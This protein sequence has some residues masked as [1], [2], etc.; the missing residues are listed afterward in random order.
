MRAE[1]GLLSRNILFRGDP[2]TSAANEYGAQIMVH[3]DGSES[4]LARI[5]YVH[6]YDCGQAFQL[7]RYPIHFHLIGVV[8][9]SYIKGNSI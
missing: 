7:G 6:F 8:H 4:L 3:A 2:E 9:N 1:V 5:E